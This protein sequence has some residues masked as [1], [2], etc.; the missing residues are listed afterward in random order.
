M[1]TYNEV[2][3]P[4]TFDPRVLREYDIRGT[5]G[6]TLHEVDAHA[7]GRKFACWMRQRGL[8]TVAVCRDGRLSSPVLSEALQKGLLEGGIDIRDV[9]IG[10]TPMLYFAVKHLHLDAGVMVTGSHNPKE[11]NGFKFTLQ[12]RPF[13]GADILEMANLPEEPAEIGGIY[14]IHALEQ[15]YIGRLEQDAEPAPKK[16]LR[17]AFDPANGAAGFIISQLVKKLNIECLVINEIIDGTF[18][19]HHPDP[20]EVKNMKQ[21]SELVLTE[22]CDL[23]IGFDGDADRLGVVDSKGRM[24]F[25]DQLMIIL[26]KDFL[27]TNPGA[28]IITD[29]KASQAFFDEV[30]RLGG[31]PIMWKTGHSLIKQRMTELNA[32]LAGEMSGHI[33]YADKYYGY[34]DGLYAAVR[35]INYLSRI[36]E[37]LAELY[38]QLPKFMSTPEIRIDSPDDKKFDVIETLKETLEKAGV[39]FDATDGVRVT[40]ANGWWLVRASNTQPKLIVRLESQTQEGLDALKQQMETFLRPLIS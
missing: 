25:G 19:A 4:H 17:V 38:D 20:T 15:A 22:K 29:V 26:A 34:D 11:D 28:K 24:L 8:K 16:T 6:Q 39:S 30:K 5:Y 40:Q 21:L 36:P 1:L 35:L 14:R 3:M 12:T 18:P 13:F 2:I 33:F 31:E 27:E 10:P 9:G 7:I 32:K 37:T 23:G